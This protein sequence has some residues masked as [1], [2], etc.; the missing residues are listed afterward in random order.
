[1]TNVKGLFIIDEVFNNL[2][3]QWPVANNLGRG[4]GVDVNEDNGHVFVGT[5][6][7]VIEFTRSGK[8]VWEFT[9]TPFVDMHSVQFTNAGTILVAEANC[10]TAFEINKQKGIVWKWWVRDHF[11]PP[12]WYDEQIEISLSGVSHS[13]R[14]THMN[15]AYRLPNGDTLITIHTWSGYRTPKRYGEV[16]RV[17]PSGIVKWQWGKDVL[18]GAHA[19]RP[20]KDGYLICDTLNSKIRYVTE[21]DGEVTHIDLVRGN[22]EYQVRCIELTGNALFMSTTTEYKIFGI[23]LDDLSTELDWERMWIWKMPRMCRPYG[24]KWVKEWNTDY[25]EEEQRV[26]R[27]Q[28]K[29][30]GY[31][32]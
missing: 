20:Y 27:K 28:M 30:L 2:L 14:W 21:K 18:K 5:D 10:D 17:N 32:D 22:M 1:M 13:R 6:K 15:N 31:I 9:Y 7:R 12:E 23:L 16:L 8:K 24:L 25:T 19:V 26:V 4:F 3:G 11:E 29:E